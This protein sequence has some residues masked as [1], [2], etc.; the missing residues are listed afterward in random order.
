MS[1]DRFEDVGAYLLGAL[2]PHEHESFELALETD[3]LL[4][5]E[6]E[7]LRCAAEALPSSAEQFMP[8]PELKGRIMAIVEVEAELLG[9]VTR[10]EPR[11]R[12]TLAALL[13]GWLSLRPGLALAATLLVLVVGGAGALV[14]QSVFSET[15]VVVNAELGDAK[16]IVEGDRKNA[17]LVV[18]NLD[19]PSPNRAYQVWLQR[20][21]Q[22]PAPTKALFTTAAD[23]TATVKV[24][25]SLEDVKAVLVTEEPEGG[26][27]SPTSAPLILARPA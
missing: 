6:V 5:A 24:P 8:P 4:S 19:P 3:E 17:K 22:P 16:L 12:R 25:G 7:R 9:S 15:Q 18:E 1:T 13:P 21:G 20:D 2:E 27:P 14:G 23:G 26:S 11:R 10:P